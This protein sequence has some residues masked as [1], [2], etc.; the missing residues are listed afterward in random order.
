MQSYDW[1]ADGLASDRPN[2]ARM[3]DYYL[4]GSHNFPADREAA[5]RAIRVYPGL[6][7]VARSNR[8]FLRRAVRFL[9]D[10]GIRQ[11]VD[12]GSGLPT[13]GNVHEVAQAAMPDARVVYVDIDLVAVTHCRMMLIGNSNTSVVQGDIR[14]PKQ[15]FDHRDLRHLIDMEKPLAVLVLGLLHFIG[16]DD[17]PAEA[18]A[19]IADM[20]A[21]GSYLAISHGSNDLR[22]EETERV[23]A[24]YARSGNPLYFRPHTEIAGYFA[25]FE[26]VPPGLVTIPEWRPTD[27][28]GVTPTAIVSGYAGVGRKP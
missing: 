4:G 26:L 12:I 20:L 9:C 11:F 1:G 3:Y 15:I 19:S 6:T 21:P 14:R 16:G 25:G 18:M 24:L 8:A 17:R 5:E 2:V 23:T 7:E 27:D 28:I 10:Q 22:P 13:I